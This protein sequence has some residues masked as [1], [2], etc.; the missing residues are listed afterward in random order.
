MK[1]DQMTAGAWDAALACEP[2]VRACV[3]R[4]LIG[5]D[6]DDAVQDALLRIARGFGLSGVLGSPER[7]AASVARSVVV[8]AM[9][10]RDVRR[11]PSLDDDD[12]ERGASLRA[13]LEDRSAKPG[14]NEAR[15]ILLAVLPKL[16]ERDAAALLAQ[17][18]G[19]SPKQLGDAR[20]WRNAKM[21][22]HRARERARR[23]ALQMF[24]H[25]TLAKYGD[26]G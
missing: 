8:D 16:T 18:D 17:A 15:E 9:R 3:H 14:D 20:G 1:P 21:I 2:M 24:A 23:T 10:R 6:A 7:Y 25:E 12:N 19:I 4:R 13:L 5:A 22:V 11:M 26:E